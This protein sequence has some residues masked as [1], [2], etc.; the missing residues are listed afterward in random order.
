MYKKRG[1]T[2]L[3]NAKQNKQIKRK[4]SDR[5]GEKGVNQKDIERKTVSE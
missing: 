3:K 2:F 5:V 4:E 1:K